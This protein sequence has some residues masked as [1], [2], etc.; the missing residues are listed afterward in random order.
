MIFL[1]EQSDHVY[2]MTMPRD[3]CF[4]ISTR[5]I[6]GTW[7][8]IIIDGDQWQSKN[9]LEGDALTFWY[10]DLCYRER[11]YDEIL[12]WKNKPTP[13]PSCDGSKR[14]EINV[15]AWQGY[16]LRICNE[17]STPR[18][19]FPCLNMAGIYVARMGWRGGQWARNYTT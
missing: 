15:I 17:N 14:L 8:P 6:C 12:E 4:I 1:L 10:I 16:A 3:A 7:D 5:K 11:I 9:K 18:F 19:P 13:G 2:I